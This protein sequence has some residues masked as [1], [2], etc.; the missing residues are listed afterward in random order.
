MFAHSG[1]KMYVDIPKSK[2]I[3]NAAKSEFRYKG[4]KNIANDEWHVFAFSITADYEKS[5]DGNIDLTSIGLDRMERGDKSFPSEDENM[6]AIIRAS[7]KIKDEIAFEFPLV[8]PVYIL[9][10]NNYN[11]LAIS[12]DLLVVTPV[13]SYDTVPIGKGST[14]DR[15]NLVSI[16][17]ELEVLHNGIKTFNLVY[18]EVELENSYFPFEITNID[19]DLDSEVDDGFSAVIDVKFL[20]N[21]SAL[22][23]SE[24]AYKDGDIA[25]INVFFERTYIE[26]VV[27]NF[28]VVM[29]NAV[30]SLKSFI[31]LPGDIDE[32]STKADILAHENSFD[33]EYNIPIFTYFEKEDYVYVDAD[34]A[35]FNRVSSDFD[36]KITRID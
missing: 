12:S 16:L 27:T 10:K 9:A 36:C 1:V 21:V 34:E 32:I 25:S 20:R 28:N 30:I 33:I 29:L 24:A 35:V 3:Q 26:E 15:S 4:V 7:K 22:E 31:E 19:I 23:G 8:E 5:I 17:S 14:I 6:H 13:H 2:L 18:K 11:S